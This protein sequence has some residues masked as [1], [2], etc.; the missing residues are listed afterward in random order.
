M[1]GSPGDVRLIEEAL[2][3]GKMRNALHT[4]RGG[5]E[6]LALLRREGEYAAADRPHR[7]LL[8]LNLPNKN[9]R[10]GA[11][12]DQSQQGPLTVVTPPP[13]STP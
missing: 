8:D 9:G 3:G 10:R 12:G 6:A 1:E 7:V 5:A 11:G 13:E 2:K 4:V